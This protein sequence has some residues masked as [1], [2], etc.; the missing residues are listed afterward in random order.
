MF[1]FGMPELILI[2]IIA[3]IVFGPQKLPDLARSLGKSLAELKRATEDFKQTIEEE[4]RSHEEEKSSAAAA[5][6]GDEK[7]VKKDATAG[8]SEQK[9]D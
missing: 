5:T 6:T 3:L 4:A 7:L 2:L 8:D 9:Q 1:G